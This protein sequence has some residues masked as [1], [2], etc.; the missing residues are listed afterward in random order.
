MNQVNPSSPRFSAVYSF[1]STIL[2]QSSSR[3]K[4]MQAV[5][6][7]ILLTSR[8]GA[9]TKKKED[10]ILLSLYSVILLELLSAHPWMDCYHVTNDLVFIRER[11]RTES[12]RNSAVVFV[13]FFLTRVVNW[14]CSAVLS[15]LYARR[16]S[17]FFRAFIAFI[18]FTCKG[19]T[20]KP[21]AG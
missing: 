6:A 13:K 2:Q 9:C 10:G 11:K 4:V 16:V 12:T 5:K 1:C 8:S 17:R 7:V 14:L 18:A 3:M 19:S 20:G 21:M 15:G